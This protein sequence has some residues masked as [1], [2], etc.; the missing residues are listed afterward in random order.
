M[1]LYEP[2]VLAQSK[3]DRREIWHYMFPTTIGELHVIQHEAPKERNILD[4]YI[5]WSNT[6][7]NQTYI[8][9]TTKMINGKE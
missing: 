9:I 7:A 4:D 3:I 5:G 6:K 2:H 8:R 1:D